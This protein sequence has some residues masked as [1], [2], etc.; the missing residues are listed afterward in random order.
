MFRSALSRRAVVAGLSSSAAAVAGGVLPARAK[1]PP[2]GTQA[3]AFYRFKIGT[4]E[5]TIV[6]DGELSLGR[7]TP[8]LFGGVTQK[9]INGMLTRRFL[10]TDN[11]ELEENALLLNTGDKLVLFDVG[12]GTSK[13]FGP[14]A[15]RIQSNLKAAGYDP[16][17]VD[18][19]VLTHA[20]P[21]HCWGLL[22]DDGTSNFPNAQI[23]LQESDLT[24][25]TDQ[26]KASDK[27]IG[28][29]I[30]PT[31]RQLLPN[32]ERI[33]FIKDGAEILPGVQAIATPGHTVGHT[34]FVVTSGGKTL[35]LTADV[36]H[37]DVLSLENPRIEMMFDT[38]PKQ[39]VATRIRVLDMLAA[40]KTPALVYHFPF[41]GIGHISKQGDGYR[42][43]P[44]PMTTAL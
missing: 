2:V 39:G 8:G 15:G 26:A 34:S 1:A 42:F 4:I 29:F 25:W 10:P 37:H 40:Q 24:F 33:A 20:H 19:I 35:L 44:M 9:T 12:V 18:A 27:A 17:D 13:A 5:A 21:D 28:S 7:P 3:P 22:A 23:F 38:D 30:E 16:K 41:P 36:C 14:K 31:R 6:S 43:N 11:V 32:R